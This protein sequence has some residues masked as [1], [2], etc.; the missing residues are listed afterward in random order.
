[1]RSLFGVAVA[2]ALAAVLLREIHGVRL[3]YDALAFV[4]FASWFA[5]AVSVAASLVDTAKTHRQRSLYFA[6]VVV[7][8]QLLGF[9]EEMDDG[10]ASL[11]AALL[12]ALLAAV[13]VMEAWSLLRSSPPVDDLDIDT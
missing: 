9:Q 3:S 6:A 13:I 8:A 7:A 5:G 4:W 12:W 1:M 11:L 10:I 2:L